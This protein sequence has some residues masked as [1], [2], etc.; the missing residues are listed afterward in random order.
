MP[1]LETARRIASAKY[2]GAK[3]I[4][5]IY[6]DT[7]DFVMLETWD[8]DIQSKICYIYDFWHDDQPHLNKGMT[9]ENT[10]KTKI[11]AKFIITQYGSIS[12]DQV[13]FHIQFKPNELLEFTQN[14]ELYY[15][16]T[17][18]HSKYNVQFPL[19][20]Y[21]DIPNEKG[22]Y[23][24]WLI[25]M[26]EQ[27]NQFPKYNVLPCNYRFEWIEVDGETRYK[28]RMWGCD[29][30][31][32]SYTSGV[33]LD[34]YFTA[35]DNVEKSYLPLNAITENI[36]YVGEDGKNQ[37]MI[38]SAKVKNPTT[39]KVTKIETT[40]PIGLLQMTFSQVSFDTHTDYIERDENGEIIG[41]WADYNSSEI[42]PVDPFEELTPTSPLNYGKIT[43]STSTIKI[44]GSYKTLIVNIYDEKG[45][46][47]TNLYSDATVNWSCSVNNIDITESGSISWLAGTVFNKSK[48]KFLNDKSYLGQ[49][50]DVNCVIT[51]DAEIIE[52]TMQFELVT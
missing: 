7:S 47:I 50:L 16:E 51:K 37:R 21:I 28:R 23:E 39:Y 29:R 10:T 33:W 46:D 43:A 27:G 5:Q 48:I 40:H 31:Q 12:K 4:G 6:K 25:V 1:S 36:N 41:M 11:D 52:T 32:L 9:Y 30:Q 15:F 44:G 35:L 17:D 38:V 34:R 8:N 13:P 2:N 24:K 20:L 42:A 18:Y 3:T 26:L 22:V 14:D 19:S 45:I 49:V